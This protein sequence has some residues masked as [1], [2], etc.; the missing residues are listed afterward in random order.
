M[1]IRLKHYHEPR[2]VRTT[3]RLDR[4]SRFKRVI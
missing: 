4:E 1:T 3:W 2:L